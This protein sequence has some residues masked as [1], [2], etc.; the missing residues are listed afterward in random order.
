MRERSRWD[1]STSA[2]S[3]VHAPSKQWR[4]A[5]AVSSILARSASSTSCQLWT[6]A[7]RLLAR[8]ETAALS[9]ATRALIIV[10]LSWSKLIGRVLQVSDRTVL[11]YVDM[12]W[13]N[14]CG[15]RG[16]SFLKNS[17]P[18]LYSSMYT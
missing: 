5:P 6:S 1:S 2:R 18:T 8:E 11:G 7:S 12:C 17:F 13:P 4:R 14:C 10:W 9:W 3:L 15:S 16:V